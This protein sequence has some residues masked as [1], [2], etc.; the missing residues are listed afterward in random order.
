M[1]TINQFLFNLLEMTLSIASIL[2]VCRYTSV[3]RKVVSFGLAERSRKLKPNLIIAGVVLLVGIFLV[4]IGAPSEYVSWALV[5]FCSMLF[6]IL[7]GYRLI[8]RKP[9]V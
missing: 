8:Y 3:G 7:V 6:W 5:I 2:L 1:P 9:T 4:V